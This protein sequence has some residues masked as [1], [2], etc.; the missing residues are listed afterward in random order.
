MRGLAPA[1]GPRGSRSHRAGGRG[2]FS[3]QGERKERREKLLIVIFRAGVGGWISI[4]LLKARGFSAEFLV[5]LLQ[6][7]VEQV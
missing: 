6:H 4:V 7:V 3:F 2:V 5:L 1:Q